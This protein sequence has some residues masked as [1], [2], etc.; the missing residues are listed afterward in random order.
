MVLRALLDK[1][2]RSRENG[3]NTD[4][5]VVTG[6]I[7]FSGKTE[8][9]E[10]ATAF[11]QQLEVASGVTMDR[12]FCVPGNHDIDRSRETMSFQGA[13]S[14]LNNPQ[15]VDEFLGGGDNFETLI[16]R[17]GSY[18]QFQKSVFDGGAKS[19]TSDGLGYVARFDV[20]G[21]KIAIM[22]LDSAWLAQGGEDDHGE[23]VM[24]ERQVINALDTINSLGDQPH[25][26]LGIAHH[27][28]RLLRE[29]DYI[30]VLNR[31]ED[32]LDFFHC[33]HLH[34]SDTR[35]AG[36]GASRCLTVTAG[37]CYQSRL[38]KNSFSVVQLDLLGGV[39]EVE[40]FDYDSV[41]DEFNS[42]GITRFPFEMR[43]HAICDV[44]ELGHAITAFCSELEPICF[45]L[46]ALLLGKKSEIPIPN[47]GHFTFGSFDALEA[48]SASEI[49]SDTARFRSFQNVLRLHYGRMPLE[50][51]LHDF[52]RLVSNYGRRLLLACDQD[53]ALRS[54]LLQHDEDARTFEKT[55]PSARNQNTLGLFEHLLAEEKWNLMLQV[56]ERH[57]DSPDP[58]TRT[59]ARRM[60]ALALA[61]STELPDKRFA[62]E[63]YQSLVDDDLADET[64]VR[65]L[66]ILRYETGE[67]GRST[68]TL[69]A[70]IKQFPQAANSF[71]SIG[72]RIAMETGDAGL[73]SKIDQA[74]GQTP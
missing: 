65:N 9:Y 60:A 53:D 7:A 35:S 1:L 14:Y 29:F 51:I 19:T 31:L 54:R 48:L 5:I 67:V 12:I 37:A 39:S 57:L 26:V 68:E 42:A 38:A 59:R 23:L 69:L 24:G 28:L 32:V 58:A 3:V 25:V 27:P 62:I 49:Q 6:D 11:F 8:E 74:T 44:T 61:N 40:A 34:H 13:R 15:R 30:P 16:E 2:E 70:G 22:G 66:A 64:D 10:L 18:R 36:T 46:S 73:R 50:Q 63:H 55:D 21:I 20:D 45:Y 71:V 17:Q 33:G 72:N 47:N 4:F 43:P 41:R 52:G 56:S